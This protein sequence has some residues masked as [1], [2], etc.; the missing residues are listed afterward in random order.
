M[1]GWTPWDGCYAAG[2]GC[3]YCF[4]YGLHSKRHGQNVIVRADEEA[5][6]APLDK[7]KYQ[8]G[9]IVGVCFSSDF[10]ISEADEWRKEAWNI[11]KQ[12]PD[13]IF[14]FLTK[15]IDRFPVS[16]PDDWGDGYENVEIG[17]GVENQET[18]DYRLPLYLSYPIKNKW[19]VCVPL[20]DQVDLTPY[21]HGVDMVSVGGEWGCEARE[22]NFDWAIDIREQ[23]INAGVTFGFG[24]TGQRFRKDGV[25]HKVSP[26]RKKQALTDLGIDNISVYVKSDMEKVLSERKIDITAQSEKA[27]LL[28]F[29]KAI[30]DLGYDFGCVIGSGSIHFPLMINYVKN[31]THNSPAAR[32]YISEGRVAVKLLLKKITPHF[33]YIKSASDSIKGVFTSHHGD[34]AACLNK[35]RTQSKYTIDGH[36]IQKCNLSRKL[37]PSLNKLPDYMDLFMEF[38]SETADMEQVSPTTSQ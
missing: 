11:I 25:L 30:N 22:F 14:R 34:C 6:Y 9:D 20:I 37:D 29:D 5:F 36:F 16:L 7:Q 10:L 33:G 1:A 12:R 23:C 26:F 19:I 24:R 38:F 17:C 27:F 15:R 21:L 3:K 4:F 8:S 18:A 32:V 2:D 35:C 28:A 13:L 31:G